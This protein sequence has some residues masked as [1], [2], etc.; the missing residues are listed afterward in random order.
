MSRLSSMSPAALRALFSPDADD[1]LIILMTLTTANGMTIRLADNYTQR[2]NETADDVVY[3]VISRGN[4]FTFLPLEITLP[5]EEQAAAPRASVVIH[6]V[7]RYLLPVIRGISG[8]M[9]CALEVVLFSAPDSVEASFPGLLMSGI[10][11]NKDV[12]TADLGVAG[13]S[14]EPFPAHTFTPSYFR[15][16]F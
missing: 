2:I 15:G 4:D 12:I 1:D 13:L 5:S 7:T 9:P 3:G 16:L 6:D 8:A 10:N 11:Y 14:V